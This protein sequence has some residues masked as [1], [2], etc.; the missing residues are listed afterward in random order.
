MNLLSDQRKLALAKFPGLIRDALRSFRRLTGFTAVSALRP[1]FAQEPIRDIP[2]P[3][4]HPRCAM[5][6]RKT[7]R[8]P[9]CEVEWQKHLRF[10]QKK[11]ACKRHICPL[12]LRCAC[13]P[14]LLGGELLGVV[15][16]V[17]GHEISAERFALAADQLELLIARPCLDLHVALLQEEIR[18]VRACVS[19]L[20]R[21]KRPA[22]LASSKGLTSSGGDPSQPSIAEPP[23]PISRAL[24]Y[25]NDHYTDRDLSLTQVASAVGK[26]E[27]Y[28]AHQF[29]L[30]VGERMHRF[31]TT[32]R[33]ERACELLLTTGRRIEEIS[34]ASGFAHSLQFRQ[35]F[36]RAMGVT[37][38]EYR[39]VFT[40]EGSTLIDTEQPAAGK[41]VPSRARQDV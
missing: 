26:N 14:V 15:K 8:K 18:A 30:Q 10:G 23:S 41:R 37:A 40:P 28:L 1:V 20:E 31:I 29:A 25:L 24:E 11:L 21:A 17:S 32:L 2:L 3:P 39:Q 33:I 35:A 36:R 7:R 27:K 19:R 16:F 4:V 38:S 22:G 13:V 12:G 34:C 6:L 5:L 9:P